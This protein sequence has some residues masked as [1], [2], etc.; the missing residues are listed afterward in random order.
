MT[1]SAQLAFPFVVVWEPRLVTCGL[2]NLLIWSQVSMQTS[3]WLSSQPTL[4]DQNSSFLLFI[5][6]G[7][8][9]VV[10]STFRVGGPLSIN[11]VW[12]LL[13]VCCHG[14]SKSHQD[15]NQGL[16]SCLMVKCCHCYACP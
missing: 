9:G 5:K 13:E 7:V 4:R 14:D 15:D 1:V 2:F 3:L 11:P 6:C 8:P 12:R 10:L 16:S